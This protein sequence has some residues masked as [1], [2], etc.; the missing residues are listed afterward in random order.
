MA[1]DVRW[2]SFWVDWFLSFFFFSPRGVV[3]SS[4][5]VVRYFVPIALLLALGMDC[6]V[7]DS[8]FISTAPCLH[9][10]ISPALVYFFSSPLARLDL[11]AAHFQ[12]TVEPI[13]VPCGFSL[14]S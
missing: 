1:F 3:A 13:A 4:P 2:G 6:H 10:S 11:A 9:A 5:S 7:I 14:S 8:L 12:V